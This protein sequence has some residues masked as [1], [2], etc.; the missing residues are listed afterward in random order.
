MLANGQLSFVKSF[1]SIFRLGLINK[2]TK[3]WYDDL[4]NDPFIYGLGI[5][6]QIYLT[7]HIKGTFPFGYRYLVLN[8]T[9]NESAFTYRINFDYEKNDEVIASVF[10]GQE[11]LV[12]LTGNSFDTWVLGANYSQEVIERLWIRIY[13]SYT[14]YTDT[15]LPEG[16]NKTSILSTSPSLEYELGRDFS[17]SVG[18][19][20]FFNKWGNASGDFS[21]NR[22]FV[23]F[24]YKKDKP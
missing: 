7:P 18:Y 12:D 13:L 21:N 3:Y 17:V 9:N 16:S 15:S 4:Q 23:M 24:S 5:E 19:N 8:Q 10:Y 22:V 14:T 1:N 20:G 6:P 11:F 2:V